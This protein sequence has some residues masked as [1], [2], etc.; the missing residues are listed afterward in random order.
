MKITY[1]A[2]FSGSNK[3]GMGLAQFS[4][5]REWQ[6]MGCEV[7]IIAASFSHTRVRQPDPGTTTEWIDGV[8]YK[9][10]PVKPYRSMIGRIRAML[11]YTLSVLKL[12][13]KVEREAPDVIIFSS[14][15]PFLFCAMKMLRRIPEATISVV[16]VRDLWGE[17]LKYLV[18][19]VW[20]SIS[21]IVSYFVS[22]LEGYTYRN[23]DLVVSSLIDFP[24]YLAERGIQV[25]SSR[26][27]WVRNAVAPM[28]A[29]PWE[30][31]ASK[32]ALAAVAE[33]REKAGLLLVYTGS[34]GRA[35]GFESILEFLGRYSEAFLVVIGS[36]D[37]RS[38]FY[39]MAD[40]VGVADRLALLPAVERS[41]LKKMLALS[42]L[43][44][45]SYRA[46]PLYQYGISPTKLGDYLQ[47]G[48]PVLYS[49]NAPLGIP[50]DFYI[51]LNG[52]SELDIERKL[53]S[54]FCETREEVARK[55]IEWAEGNFTAA[56]EARRYLE[57]LEP[58]CN[59]SGRV[60]TSDSSM[61]GQGN[62]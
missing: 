19:G 9:W 54:F 57:F 56:I 37:R 52:D 40:A 17:S 10:I 26:L 21:R 5:A 49:G 59:F 4:L 16:E 8:S 44:V 33:L 61:V 38:Q 48:K 50:E 11:Q 28:E 55:I 41:A 51:D 23:T 15:H 36:G 24:K 20:G 62:G 45:C 34:L 2:Q 1:L 7:E 47:A 39:D 25:D 42:D 35:T 27:F 32:L 46:S 31:K 18:D 14:Y 12:S 43:C 3:H 22:K 29:C 60:S 30:E 53:D 58:H 13:S 6:K